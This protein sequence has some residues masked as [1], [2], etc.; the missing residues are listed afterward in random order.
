MNKIYSV[1]IASTPDEMTSVRRIR[2]LV[3][4]DEQQIPAHLD[5]DGEDDAAYHAICLNNGECVAT[6]RLVINAPGTGIVARIAV[7]PEHRGSGLGKLIVKQLE[8]VA[9]E[10][11]VQKLTLH[12]HAYL[13]KFY[14]DLGYEKIPGESIVGEHHLITMQK[15][16]HE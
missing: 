15:I 4:T 14:T 2:Q 6:G 8:Q 5:D 3:F 7:I 12:P 9:V 1:K 11:R 13:E 16:Y 10:Q